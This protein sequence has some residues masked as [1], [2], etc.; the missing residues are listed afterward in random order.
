VDVIIPTNLVCVLFGPAIPT[1]Y[2][3]FIQLVFI[4]VTLPFFIA[5]WAKPAI[6][7]IQQFYL[8]WLAHLIINFII[9]MIKTTMSVF[10]LS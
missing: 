1:S 6:H 8:A 10:S 4:I 2:F 9:G 3:N 5:L 7:V